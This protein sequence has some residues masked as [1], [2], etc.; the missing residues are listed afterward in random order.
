MSPSIQRLFGENGVRCV[1]DEPELKVLQ[2]KNPAQFLIETDCEPSP[3]QPLH[4]TDGPC[5]DPT[6]VDSVFTTW[7]LTH[8]RR[9]FPD[10]ELLI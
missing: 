1:D 8:S 6:E 4:P 2:F 7:M 3:S 5:S 10:V 9:S